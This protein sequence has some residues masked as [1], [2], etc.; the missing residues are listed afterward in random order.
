M[1]GLNALDRSGLQRVTRRL[2]KEMAEIGGANTP[3][4]KA[5]GS[6][7][8]K[9]IR[10]QVATRGSLYQG[11]HR[12][13][14]TGKPSKVRG[15][16]SAPGESPHRITGRLYKS[17]GQAVVGGVR[18][19]GSGWFTSRLLQDGVDADETRR[20]KLAAA[21]SRGRARRRRK[22]RRTPHLTIAARPFMERALA[23]ALPVMGNDFLTQIQRRGGGLTL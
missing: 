21:S 10:K 23:A 16:P 18:R 13:S 6:A 2:A 20:Q 12:A 14:K 7:L 4:M 22:A 5:A 9:S 15:T 17:I 8:A 1:P 11:P 19:V 3:E